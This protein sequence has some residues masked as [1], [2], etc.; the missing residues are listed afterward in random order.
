MLFN[1]LL[2]VG[3][4][5]AFTAPAFAE[6]WEE[7]LSA[8]NSSNAK[9]YFDR[10]IKPIGAGSVQTQYM[11]VE[12]QPRPVSRS[13]PDGPSYDKAIFRAVINCKDYAWRFLHRAYYLNGSVQIEED[14]PGG[15]T[16]SP[17][18]GSAP[19]NISEKACAGRR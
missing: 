19:Y 9:F 6:E 14:T 15:A 3:T 16:T 5:I 7:V 10:D 17:P 12:T 4:L 11:I 1:R 8:K 13:K 2:M 18:S